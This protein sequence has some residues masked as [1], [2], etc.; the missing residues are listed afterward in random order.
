[1]AAEA[2]LAQLGPLQ[3]ELLAVL[4]ALVVQVLRQPL[5]VLL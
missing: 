3:L 5:Q 4:L 2:V 1:V